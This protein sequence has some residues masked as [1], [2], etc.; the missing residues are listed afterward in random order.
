MAL[1]VLLPPQKGCRGSAAHHAALGLAAILVGEGTIGVAVPAA[2]QTLGVEL[3]PLHWHLV[4][5][6]LELL[7]VYPPG[8]KEG[9]VN[10][11]YPHRCAKTD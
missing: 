5:L 9:I 1:L 4:H 11:E 3:A 10:Q 7:V 6:P 8:L 2:V